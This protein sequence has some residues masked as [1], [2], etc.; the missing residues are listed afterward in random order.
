[1]S[2]RIPGRL[3]ELA[4]VRTLVAMQ[5]MEMAE[6]IKKRRGEPFPV[7]LD[8]RLG[9]MDT[10]TIPSY[11]IKQYQVVSLNT[12]KGG[13][14]VIHTDGPAEQRVPCGCLS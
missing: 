13:T 8:D 5:C 11:D 9:L 4:S 1:M 2:T 6:R 14:D 7:R 3:L 12:R 10:H